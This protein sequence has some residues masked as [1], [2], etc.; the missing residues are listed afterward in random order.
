MKRV[1]GSAFYFITSSVF[2]KYIL[3]RMCANESLM[4]HG[5][6]FCTSESFSAC[7]QLLLQV[8]TVILNTSFQFWRWWEMSCSCFG[9]SFFLSV[10]NGDTYY[11]SKHVNS[12][13]SSSSVELQDVIFFT[14]W[15]SKTGLQTIITLK[16]FLSRQSLK[17]TGGRFYFVWAE[18]P[19]FRG[20]IPGRSR[21]LFSSTKKPDRIWVHS[22][23]LYHW[24]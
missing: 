19:N 1:S 16:H 21:R 4:L 24:N 17:K 3:C 5:K 15:G 2:R 20:S 9:V 18:S 8:Y 6:W 14:I 7:T 22:S 10:N 11:T 12:A 13:V 23:L